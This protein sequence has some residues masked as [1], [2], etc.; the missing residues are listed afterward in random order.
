MNQ[1]LIF[2]ELRIMP[3]IFD[4]A[5]TLIAWLGFS[6]LVYA[7][8]MT[9]LANAPFIGFGPLFS[10]VNT[11]TFYLIVALINAAVLIGWAKYNQIRFRVERR[12][13]RPGL[14]RDELAASF[15]I[16]PALVQDLSNGR[17]LTVFHY[18]T[19][20]ISRAEVDKGLIA[21]VA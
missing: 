21:R 16:A 7:G 2:T 14:G 13:R 18:D 19:G 10:T 12:K 5:L 11:V 4:V 8:L 3:R 17:V 20:A 1:P 9:A 6:Y 15:S